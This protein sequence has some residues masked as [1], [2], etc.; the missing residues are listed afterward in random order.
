MGCEEGMRER[1]TG[2]ETK[3]QGNMNTVPRLLVCKAPDFQMDAD[4]LKCF[5]SGGVSG[6]WY[7]TSRALHLIKGILHHKELQMIV[8]KP[9]TLPDEKYADESFL[10]ICTFV[11]YASGP[12]ARMKK[13]AT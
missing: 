4:L 1:E 2:R 13:D 8:H 12:G 6:A 3:M 7:L 5:T 11:N 10:P 9:S